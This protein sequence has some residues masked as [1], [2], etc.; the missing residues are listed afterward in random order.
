MNALK[1]LKSSRHGCFEK[2]LGATKH[3]VDA[4]SHDS[5]VIIT[6]IVTKIQGC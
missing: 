1:M 5:S 4:V 6:N 3:K 2:A